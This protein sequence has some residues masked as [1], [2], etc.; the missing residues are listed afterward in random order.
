MAYQTHVLV[1]ILCDLKG[2]STKHINNEGGTH[3]HNWYSTII[4][5][6]LETRSKSFEMF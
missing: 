3:R 2:G 4:F 1:G 6:E 5:L